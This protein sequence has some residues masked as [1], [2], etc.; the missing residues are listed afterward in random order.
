[1][2]F[3]KISSYLMLGCTDR[4]RAGYPLD[5]S[6]AGLE[7]PDQTPH[8]RRSEL[9]RPGDNHYAFHSL[10]ATSGTASPKQGGV[11]TAGCTTKSAGTRWCPAHSAGRRL[12]CSQS[13]RV[14]QL[15]L[16]QRALPTHC[17]SHRARARPAVST[18]P[19]AGRQL[20]GPALAPRR[21]IDSSLA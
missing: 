17:E 10:S 8:H 19:L 5:S 7:R 21:A 20:I 4:G 3:S 15:R 14:P 2:L 6:R 1:M 18:D 12:N 9:L 13:R 16:A 11:V